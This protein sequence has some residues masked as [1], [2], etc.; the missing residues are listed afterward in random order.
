[1]TLNV[2]WIFWMPKQNFIHNCIASRLFQ[3][4]IGITFLLLSAPKGTAQITDSTKLVKTDTIF[5]DTIPVVKI[6]KYHSPKKAAILSAALPGAGQIY[7][8][9]YWK[10]PVIYAGAAGLVYSFQ[11][12][13]SRY[14]KYRNAYKYRIDDDASTVDDYIGVYSDE[15]LNNLQKYYHRY[16]DLTVIGFAV[17]Y[18]LNIIDASVDAHLFTFDVSDDLSMNVQPAFINTAGTNKY[19]AGIGLSVHF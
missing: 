16:R 3:L 18:A 17:V 2:S 15:N 1:M 19:T 13:H 14:I 11:F 9:K 12:N 4:F 7:N 10:V 5:N 8:K 6:T